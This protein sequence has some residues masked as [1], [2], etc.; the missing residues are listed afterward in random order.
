M[1]YKFQ[2]HHPNLISCFAEG[3]LVQSEKITALLCWIVPGWEIF[4]LAAAP[5]AVLTPLPP[6]D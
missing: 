2:L 1:K 3:L 6:R 5:G 4:L